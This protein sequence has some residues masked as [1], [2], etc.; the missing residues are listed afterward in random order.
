MTTS[1][2]KPLMTYLLPKD[3]ERLR[4]F[5]KKNN[6]PMT[7]VVREAINLRLSEHPYVT[8]FNDGLKEAIKSVHNIKASQMKFPSGKSFAELVEDEVLLHIIKENHEADRTTKPV[9]IV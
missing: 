8:G 3:I 5:S 2:F 6:V 1:N 7:Q 9:P 4:K